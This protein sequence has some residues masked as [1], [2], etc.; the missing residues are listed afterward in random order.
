LS[1][2]F[3]RFLRL[4]AQATEVSDEQAITQA[5]KSLC[6][7][8]LHSHLVREHPKML[9]ELYEEFRKF[10][11][12][13][14]LHFHKLGQQRKATN[15]NESSRPFKYSKGKEGAPTFDATHKQVHSID[16][17]KCGSLE[18]WEKNFRPPC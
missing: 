15:D 14:V 18:N 13:E 17:E 7:G 4:K 9:E 12:V 10:S 16:S 2:F 11:R 6:T 1:G 5:I 3:R 8:Q